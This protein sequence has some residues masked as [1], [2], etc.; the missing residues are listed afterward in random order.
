MEAY[1]DLTIKMVGD[2]VEDVRI[3]AMLADGRRFGCDTESVERS[4]EGE[5]RTIS[6]TVK[7]EE[8]EKL[9]AAINGLDDP[10]EAFPREFGDFDNW[11]GF[12]SF[13]DEHGIVYSFS[14]DD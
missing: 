4:G 2:E 1:I 12:S 14:L 6:Y 13:C 7:G 9:L 5:S 11:T 10:S 8:V 3:S